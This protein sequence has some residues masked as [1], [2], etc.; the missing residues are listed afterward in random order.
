MTTPIIEFEG[1]SKNFGGVRALEDVSFAFTRGEIHA[2]VGE[3]GAGKSTLIRICG[4]VFPPDAGRVFFED[5]AVQFQHTLESR[6]AGI[7]IVHQ[8]IPLCPDLTAAENVLMGQKLPNRA[9]VIGWAEVNRRV[10]AVFDRLNIDIDPTET[11]RYLPIA[12]QQMVAIAQ[13]L[14]QEAKLIFM[15]EPTSALGKQETDHLFTLIHQLKAQGVT[16]I[17]V[18]HRLEEVFDI[19][20]QITVLRDGSYIGTVPRAETTP[21]AVVH[22]MVGREIDNL[23]PKACADIAPA[24]LLSVRDLSVSGVFENV[25][26]DLHG[27]EVLGLAG[28]QGSGISEVMRAIFGQ[29]PNMSGEIQVHGRPVTIQSSLDAIRRSIAYIPANRQAEGLFNIMSVRT[30]LGILSLER[31]ARLLGWVP[32]SRLNKL[33]QSAIHEFRIRTNT[34]GDPVSS[35]SGGNQQKVVVA[36]WLSVDPLII[37]MDDPTRG[38]DV[39]AKAEIHELLNQLT[40]QGCGVVMIS[41]E[42]P[43]VLAMCDRVLVM[44]RGQVQ[45]ILPRDQ[46]DRDTVMSLATGV[47]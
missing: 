36:R 10:K 39:G 29:H 37:L 30:N 28:L 20:D 43:E 14:Y 21:D 3:N 18:S 44:Y 1:V 45:A 8:E 32:G 15:D 35:L 2:L 33:A 13:A 22:M 42:L 41:S 11:V 27:G 40:A 31:I 4:G 5:R 34:A 38:V 25:S 26:F 24:P 23:F 19:A 7:S 46:A 9:G 17:Y 16:V 12:K 47:G 6:Q